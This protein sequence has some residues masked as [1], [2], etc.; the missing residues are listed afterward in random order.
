MQVEQIEPVRHSVQ[1]ILPDQLQP[2]TVAA[3]VTTWTWHWIRNPPS[4]AAMRPVGEGVAYSVS[5]RTAFHHAGCTWARSTGRWRQQ[6]SVVK[7]AWRK[8]RGRRSMA[9]CASGRPTTA[10]DPQWTPV[11]EHELRSV[12]R[13][14]RLAKTV[15][16]GYS[17][18]EPLRRPPD[19]SRTPDS[20]PGH[21]AAD[22]AGSRTRLHR[23]TRSS[24]G[25]LT[26]VKE[27]AVSEVF[28]PSYSSCSRP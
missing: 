26:S 24:H 27:Q 28:R 1:A 8:R 13:R 23:A 2:C 19:A 10:N 11:S 18:G 6:R 25:T 20:D 9:S 16:S 12:R 7:R 5:D 15:Q 21:S 14:H 4:V 3:V 17:G 22:W